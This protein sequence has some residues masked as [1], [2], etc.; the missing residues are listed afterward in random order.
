MTS[1]TFWSAR[2]STTLRWCRRC[3]AVVLSWVLQLQSISFC[4]E[5]GC[6]GIKF[7]S[8]FH[9]RAVVPSRCR[10]HDK[11]SHPPDAADAD[12][13]Y[14]SQPCDTD[15]AQA[16]SQSISA[17]RVVTRSHEVHGRL[18]CLSLMIDTGTHDNFSPVSV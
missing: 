2:G 14:K 4:V 8:D 17:S 13:S 11:E 1:P 15:F 7:Y 18:P 16:M 3:E 9:F 5:G 6:I 12:R 10:C